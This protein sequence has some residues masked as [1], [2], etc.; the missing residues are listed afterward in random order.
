MLP[1]PVHPLPTGELVGQTERD[2][3]HAPLVRCQEFRGAFWQEEVQRRQGPRESGG[4]TGDAVPE[5][6]C[7]LLR[8][9]GPGR[10]CLTG[11]LLAPWPRHQ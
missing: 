4:P 5:P 1:E 6:H 7:P 2:A 11:F 8:G 10:I 9:P 3:S